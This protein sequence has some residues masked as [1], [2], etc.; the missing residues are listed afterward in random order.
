MI[1]PRLLSEHRTDDAALLSRGRAALDFSAPAPRLLVRTDEELRVHDLPAEGGPVP[2]PAAAFAGAGTMPFASPVAHDLSH[3]VLYG[4]GAYRIVDRSGTVVRELPMAEHGGTPV[5][6]AMWS[7]SAQGEPQVWLAVPLDPSLDRTVPPDQGVCLLRLDA[8]GRPLDRFAVP[9]GDGNPGVAPIIG[10]D[11][12]LVAVS[13]L[14]SLRPITFLVTDGHRLAPLPGHR[15][16]PE[17]KP[18]RSRFVTVGKDDGSADFDLRVHDATTGAA[19]AVVTLADLLDSEPDTDGLHLA[20]YISWSTGGRLDDDSLVV[21]VEDGD[22]DD[23]AAPDA[24]PYSHWLVTGGRS[25]GR[26][27]Y[28]A[29]HSASHPGGARLPGDGTW[30]TADQQALYRW[31]L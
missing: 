27:V 13:A 18:V 7:R 19:E 25:R 22:E 29:P 2:P 23:W 24:L 16:S 14:G 10:D 9:L 28:P 17:H 6:S 31:S 1:T 30:F 15:R 12:R 26:I 5:T 20:P 4:T 21:A 11:G 3:A 8:Q